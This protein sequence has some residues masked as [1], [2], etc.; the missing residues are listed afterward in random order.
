[1]RGGGTEFLYSFLLLSLVSFVLI[2]GGELCLFHLT[3][4]IV[5]YFDCSMAA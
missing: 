2:A 5:A 3:I 4:W 1:M